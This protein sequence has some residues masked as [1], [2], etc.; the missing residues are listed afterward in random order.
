[1]ALL[2]EERPIYTWSIWKVVGHFG[3]TLA[4]LILKYRV[5][6]L[7]RPLETPTGCTSGA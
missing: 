1:M 5:P 4:I 7:P 2:I 6:S 3:E